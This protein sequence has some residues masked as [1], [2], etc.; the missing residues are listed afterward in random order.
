VSKLCSSQFQILLYQ[1]PETYTPKENHLVY[2]YTNAL[3]VHLGFLLN[4]KGPKTLHE[5]Y[6]MVIQIEA[7]IS[8][9]K[10]K[11]IF[12]LGTKINDPKDTSDTLS[13]VR[14]VSLEAFTTDFQEEGEQF[15]TNKMLRKKILMRF[16]KRK[17]LLKKQ[18]RS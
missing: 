2:L 4:K 1:I 6:N 13:L 12:S 15:L 17:G 18:L 9:S 8:L 11:H 10:G 3:L 14:S 5:I 16:S 7:N